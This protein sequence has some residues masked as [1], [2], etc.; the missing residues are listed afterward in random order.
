MLSWREKEGTYYSWPII[1]YSMTTGLSDASHG[2][3]CVYVPIIITY[4]PYRQG[5]HHNTAAAYALLCINIEK[6][7]GC[8]RD[9]AVPL[10]LR[11]PSNQINIVSHRRSVRSG[12][13]R[14]G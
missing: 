11:D 7:R 10:D 3:N 4:T 5:G 1:S 6:M 9:R 8:G 2:D 13:D 12:P 14:D